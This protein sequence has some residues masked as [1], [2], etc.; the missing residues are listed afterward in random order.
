MVYKQTARAGASMIFFVVVCLIFG[1]QP[2]SAQT[3][4]QIRDVQVLNTNGN[5]VCQH[6]FDPSDQ[7]Y[8]LAWQSAPLESVPSVRI[9]DIDNDNEEEIV[10]T[11]G[12]V[13]R[14][15]ARK[16]NLPATTY[17]KFRIHVFEHGQTAYDGSPSWSV[18]L[19]EEITAYLIDSWVDDLDNDG[20]P[21]F[22]DN[23]IVLMRSNLLDIF[24]V[25]HAN[26]DPGPGTVV[27]KEHLFT[28][29]EPLDSIDVGD[30]D[31]QPGNEIV[32]EAEQIPWVWKNISGQWRQFYAQAV[33]LDQYGDAT[34]VNLTYVRIRNADNE[35]I[36]E[37]IAAGTNERLMVWRWNG[38]GL[39][40]VTNSTDLK[41]SMSYGVDWGNIDGDP[42]GSGEV[43]INVWG[44]RKLPSRLITLAYDNGLYV[45]QNTYNSDYTDQRDLR[46]ADL[47]G[48][49]RAEVIQNNGGDPAGLKI[50]RFVGDTLQSGHF[51]QVYAAPGYPYKRIEI[52]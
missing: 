6:I 11:V 52:R 48:D 24:H 17:Y 27:S 21:G 38:G 3:P 37:V 47:T 14:T 22:A 45:I 44:E 43:V 9:G 18:D 16:K 15:E 29:K 39:D 2:A 34:V 28:Y 40:Y 12:Y 1:W 30:I 8:K 51:E 25:A 31:G 13:S 33:P 5:R 35:G 20:Q 50:F 42:A 46:I 26:N 23:E 19:P 7:T 49:G 32:V 36:N 41:G 4:L 10:A